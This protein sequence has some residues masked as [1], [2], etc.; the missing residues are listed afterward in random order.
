MSHLKLSVKHN[1]SLEEARN[2]LETAVHQ[3]QSRF[4]SMVHR[5]VWSADRDAVKMYGTGFEVEMRVDAQEVHVTADLPFLTGLLGSPFV[6]G[7][8]G[9]VE[10]TFHKRL[11]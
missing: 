11:K 6:A 2:Q 3:V 7:L 4:G 8:K 10:Q 1:R 5:V 9:I